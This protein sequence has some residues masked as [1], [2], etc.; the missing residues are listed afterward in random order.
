MRFKKQSRGGLPHLLILY[1]LLSSSRT[2][3][4]FEVSAAAII[5]PDEISIKID[6]P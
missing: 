3:V 2:I 1:Q 6:A 5:N 4:D